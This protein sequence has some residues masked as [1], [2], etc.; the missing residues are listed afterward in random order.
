[1]NKKKNKYIITFGSG[2]LQSIKD[3]VNPQKV[4]LI[5]EDTDERL[6]RMKVFDSFIG[7]NFSTSYPYNEFY[8]K[9]KE[10]YGM[11]EYTLEKLVEMDKQNEN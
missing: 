9:F 10:K 4:M 3:K 7:I 11:K 8:K 5:I 1:M 2:Q 6:A